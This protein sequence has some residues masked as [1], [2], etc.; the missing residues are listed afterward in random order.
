MGCGRLWG[1]GSTGSADASA[2]TTSG[3][4]DTYKT[5]HDPE[6]CSKTNQP[7]T[8]NV[9]ACA[10]PIRGQDDLPAIPRRFP[11]TRLHHAP[12]PPPERKVRPARS[13][14]REGRVLARHRR[15]L[16]HYHRKPACYFTAGGQPESA[17]VELN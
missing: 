13:A 8:R 6:E 9:H 15:N 16:G 3:T 1:G 4:A 7:S 17:A 5:L 11:K 2:G 14:R 12:P 10:H